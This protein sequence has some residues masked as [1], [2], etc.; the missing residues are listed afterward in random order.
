M[1]RL[2]AHFAR[3]YI[4]GENIDDA[5]S[6]ARE[7]NNHGILASIDNLGEMVTDPE[8]ARAGAAE[9]TRLLETI[10]EKG[11]NANVSLKLTHMGLEIGDDVCR[12][13]LE[14]VITKAREVGNF[15]W[16]DMEGSRYTERTIGI[17]IDLH[18]RY[19]NT[20]IAIQSALRR[21]EGDVACLIEEGARVR[22]V[23]GA[24][25]EP[26]AIA[27]PEKKEVDG[28]FERLMVELLMKG[29]EP[30]I[31]THDMTLV[32]KALQITRREKISTEHFEFQMLLGI[33][34][35]VQKRLADEGY[36]MRVYVPYG[37]AWLPY[38]MRRLRER[39]E[40]ILFILRNL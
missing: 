16:F 8:H 39:R 33:K 38:T 24:Y 20:G 23:K 26:P 3:R 29:N 7:L 19:G 6:V 15:V 5:I 21:S 37:A 4:A 34:R 22:L 18:R 40:N 35:G 2:L 28:N 9:Y 36:R 14:R 13:N 1:H 31:A 17:F 30:A 10:N 11:I 25:K 12:E 27:F 32:E